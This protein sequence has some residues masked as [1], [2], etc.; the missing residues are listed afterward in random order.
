MT[1]AHIAAALLITISALPAQAETYPN[2][3][4]RIL[5]GYSPSGAAD[6][7]ARIVGDA[8]AKELGQPILIDNKPGAGST[9]SSSILSRAAPDGYTLGLA[10]GTLYG[11]DQAL[12]KARYTPA[13]FTAITRLTV[14]PLI[15]AVNKD[16]GIANLNDLI[17]YAR[18]KGPGELNYSSSGVGGLPHIAALSFEKAVGVKMTHVPYKGGGPALQAVAAG[19][20]QLSFGTAASVLP[21]GRGGALRML[22][23]T[24][25]RQSAI[26]PDL[27]PLANAGLPGFDF[28]FWFGLFGPA[29]LPPKVSDRL[30]AA[31][32]KVLAD[33]QLQ[34]KLLGTGSEVAPSKSQAEF[35][36]WAEDNTR[37]ILERLN[38]AGVKP[39]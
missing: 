9:L 19:N 13:D 30:F 22:G 25:P 15:L 28:T 6:F 8:M 29:G 17:A 31:A 12:Y 27:A 11:I 34:A 21:L 37:V 33:P 1:Q 5:V 26:A 39:E 23:V 2:K 10:T 20:V 35:R 4:I 24:T 38:Q 18:K 7:V 32:S 36:T 16:M 14:S 3:P